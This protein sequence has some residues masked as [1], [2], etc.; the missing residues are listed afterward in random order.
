MNTPDYDLDNLDYKDAKLF[1]KRTFC[2]FYMSLIRN[3]HIIFF[4]FKPKYEFNSKIIRFC[5]LLFLFPLYLT[6]NAFYVDK[7]TIHN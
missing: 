1:D 5:F 2:Q 6:I 7:F 4:I 3:K